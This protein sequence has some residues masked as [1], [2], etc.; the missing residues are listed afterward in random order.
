MAVEEGRSPGA[1][2][3]GAN[4]EQIREEGAGAM[5]IEEIAQVLTLLDDHDVHRMGASALTD[6][7]ALYAGEDDHLSG[8]LR[9]LPN[10]VLGCHLP[11]VDVSANHN[12]A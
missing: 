5:V 11:L 12:L 6:A 7:L 1:R 3:A 9:D 10:T 2:L 4:F 8:S